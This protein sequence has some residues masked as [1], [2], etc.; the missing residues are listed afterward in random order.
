MIIFVLSL[1]GLITDPRSLSDEGALTKA[2]THFEGVPSSEGQF[3]D[4]QQNG[5]RTLSI[6]DIFAACE[7]SPRQ[8]NHWIWLDQLW[9]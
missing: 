9:Y 1:S 5:E 3:N 4:K 2:H 6:N 8:R 7:V